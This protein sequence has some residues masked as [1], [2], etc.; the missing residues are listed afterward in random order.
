[1]RDLIVKNWGMAFYYLKILGLFPEREGY[2]TRK[3]LYLGQTRKENEGGLVAAITR[4]IS[5]DFFQD[6]AAHC[7]QLFVHWGI[8]VAEA[9]W[10]PLHI[11]FR[12]AHKLVE[13]VK[14][15]EIFLIANFLSHID[16]GARIAWFEEFHL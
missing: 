11:D 16:G 2:F 14:V 9:D 10:P 1:M 6:I 15:E 3:H 13:S 12:L 5:E 8:F 7:I 4:R